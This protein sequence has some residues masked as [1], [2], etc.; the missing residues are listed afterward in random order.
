MFVVM[1]WFFYQDCPFYLVPPSPLELSSDHNNHKNYRPATRKDYGQTS[2]NHNKDYHPFLQIHHF[3]TQNSRLLV[4]YLILK[5][6]FSLIYHSFDKFCIIS[7]HLTA[8]QKQF[9]SDWFEV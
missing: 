5:L 6:N 2:D 7:N 9:Q 8:K 1:M 4:D 3:H